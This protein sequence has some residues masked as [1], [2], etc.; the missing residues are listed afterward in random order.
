MSMKKKLLHIVPHVLVALAFIV[1]ALAFAQSQNAAFVPLA[2]ITVRGGSL[3]GNTGDLSTFLNNVFK[4]ALTVGAIGAVLRLAYAGYLY[5]GQ[6]DMWSHKGQAK[7]IIGDVTLGLLLLLSIWLILYQINPDILTL[8][9]LKNIKPV[10]QTSQNSV[11]G[12]SSLNCNGLNS[13]TCIQGGNAAQTV[14][15]PISDPNGVN[16]AGT[17]QP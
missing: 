10:Q 13:G 15:T 7:A 11:G 5:M 9:A 2:P 1:P 16:N 17:V 6:A 3:Y 8:N 14:V 4:F 12:S